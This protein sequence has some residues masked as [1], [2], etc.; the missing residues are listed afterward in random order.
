MFPLSRARELLPIE[1]YVQTVCDR[2][3]HG[4]PPKVLQSAPKCC[5]IVLSVEIFF[6]I[7]RVGFFGRLSFLFPKAPRGAKCPARRCNGIYGNIQA[8]GSAKSCSPAVTAVRFPLGSVISAEA[9]S[10][11]VT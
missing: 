3:I 10:G 1:R 11:T 6:R 4:I 7:K 5:K 9:P 2:I 8:S